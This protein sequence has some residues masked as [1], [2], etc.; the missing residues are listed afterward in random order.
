MDWHIDYLWP[1]DM[2]LPLQSN[3]FIQWSEL[4]G[5]EPA[6]CIEAFEEILG[7]DLLLLPTQLP[8][9]LLNSP[10][11]PL[12]L[13]YQF[14][15][16][17][18]RLQRLRSESWLW[19]RVLGLGKEGGV[20]IA[21]FLGQEPEKIAALH[22]RQVLLRWICLHLV[23]SRLLATVNLHLNILIVVLRISQLFPTPQ[24]IKPATPKT[25]P[26]LLA[27]KYFF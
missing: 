22:L 21:L 1:L 27:E 17:L 7:L 15:Q 13:L 4:W 10:H 3:A 14:Y 9:S 2:A 19:G 26:R 20:G 6:W 24:A 5:A 18:I 12:I 25:Y 23:I 8:E 11:I 16:F